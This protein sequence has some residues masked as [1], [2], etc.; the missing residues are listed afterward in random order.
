MQAIRRVV[1]GHGSDGKSKVVIDGSAG[2]VIDLGFNCGVTE[3][4]ATF[5]ARPSNLGNDD[6]ALKSPSARTPPQNGDKF[7]IIEF[8]PDEEVDLEEADRRMAERIGAGKMLG[9]VK[10]HLHRSETVDYAIVLEG[11]ISHLTESDEVLLRQGDVLIQRGTYHAWRNRSK[12]PA[13]VAVILLDAQPLKPVAAA[14]G[15]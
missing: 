4:W 7:R 10:G 6:A 5:E 8:A 1:T 3:L 12:Q 9:S 2:T 13:L 14:T 11:E 15:S